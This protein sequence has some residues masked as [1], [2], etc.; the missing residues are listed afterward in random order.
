MRKREPTDVQA[1]QMI[2][3]QQSRCLLGTGFSESAEI[4]CDAA[5]SSEAHVQ[6]V[7]GSMFPS[8]QRI[9]MYGVQHCEVYICREIFLVV[10]VWVV[11]LCRWTAAADILM[12]DVRYEKRI[13]LR[14][15]ATHPSQRCRITYVD[16][17]P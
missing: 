2:R 6:Q 17:K 11:M 16:A 5:E 15:C 9:V 13:L 7:S 8:L 4:C 3:P 14:P 12:K 1:P 10:P